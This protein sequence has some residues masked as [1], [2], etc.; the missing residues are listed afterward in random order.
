MRATCLDWRG[1]PFPGSP[2]LLPTRKWP[3]EEAPD[4][5]SSTRR[6]C[7]KFGSCCKTNDSQQVTARPWPAWGPAQLQGLQAAPLRPRGMQE[8]V[9]AGASRARRLP[10]LHPWETGPLSLDGRSAVVTGGGPGLCAPLHPQHPSSSE[11]QS[12]PSVCLC[13]QQRGGG[14]AWL[15]RHPVWCSPCTC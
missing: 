2:G 8:D 5:T 10:G 13:L 3:R 6:P 1:V 15:S 14:L 9:G 12:C 7:R 4:V 11:G